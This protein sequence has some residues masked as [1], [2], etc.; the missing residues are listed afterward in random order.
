MAIVVSVSC[1]WHWTFECDSQ[2][3]QILYSSF[4]SIHEIFVRFTGQN[5]VF[6]PTLKGQNVENHLNTDSGKGHLST[7]NWEGRISTFMWL[8][9]SASK[10]ERMAEGVPKR[11]GIIGPYRNGSIKYGI[12]NKVR[13]SIVETGDTTQ[14]LSR[15]KN[16]T[17][18]IFESRKK[19]IASICRWIAR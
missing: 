12:V 15:V 19:L 13:S 7:K 3:Q 14:W 4:A 8:P 18:N 9:N 16:K 2:L 6:Y 11:S 1:L 10:E 5:F 17:K